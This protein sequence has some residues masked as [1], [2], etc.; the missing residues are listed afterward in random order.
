MNHSFSKQNH[1]VLLTFLLGCLLFI[2]RGIIFSDYFFPV[3]FWNTFLAFIPWAI[4]KEI[5][6]KSKRL[7][8]WTQG[9]IWLLFL[10][11][12]F[13]V[14]TDLIHLRE[15]SGQT[16]W[17]DLVL[18]LSFTAC[19][20]LMGFYSFHNIEKIFNRYRS[21]VSRLAFRGILFLACSYGLFLGRVL[22]WNTWDLVVR[23]GKVLGSV[24][25]SITTLRID[26]LAFTISFSFFIF[27]FLIYHMF[28][29][30]NYQARKEH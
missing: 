30:V 20:F 2:A 27:L 9:V 21:N 11:N 7:W 23:P 19:S 13:Y 26:S 29:V 5:T 24:A 3:I 4:S 12:A 6:A 17:M 8:R 28:F 22:R 25:D 10:P 18:L 16:F 14:A 15:S 1:F